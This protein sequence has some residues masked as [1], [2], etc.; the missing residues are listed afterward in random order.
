MSRKI[1]ELAREQQDEMD[2]LLDQDAA[3]PA[4]AEEDEGYVHDLF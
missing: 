4:E 2:Q 1:L 3:I